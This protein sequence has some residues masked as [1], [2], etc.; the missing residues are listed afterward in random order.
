MSTA[1]GNPS[2]VSSERVSVRPD[3]NLPQRITASGVK[4]DSMPSLTIEAA[5]VDWDTESRSYVLRRLSIA[6]RGRSGLTT[7]AM[8]EVTV[9][10]IVSLCFR[11]APTEESGAAQL[12]RES[13]EFYQQLRD[14]KSPELLYWV[15]KRAAVGQAI[16]GAPNKEVMECFGVPQRTASRWIAQAREAGLLD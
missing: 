9:P 4:S 10:E 12:G 5:E 11:L 2:A 7:T 15:A 3:L 8:R 1:I 16:S 6:P 13:R 14:E